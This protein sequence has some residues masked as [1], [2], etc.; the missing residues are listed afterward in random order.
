[1]YR[2][3]GHL[4]ALALISSFPALAVADQHDDK[5]PM[6]DGSKDTMELTEAAKEKKKRGMDTELYELTEDGM[7][8]VIGSVKIRA[9][10]DGVLFVPDIS[11]LT[12]GVHGFH[13]HENPDCGTAE[14]DGKT[15]PGG[16]AGGHY[17]PGGGGHNGPYQEGHKGDLPALYADEDGEVT[18]PVLAPRLTIRDLKD[19]ALIV[20]QHGDNYSDEPKALGGGGPRVACGVIGER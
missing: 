1:M 2:L 5:K 7:G 3:T 16:A 17:N 19:R 11:G 9:N 12:P 14:K 6:G 15:V 13:V 10:P 4:A 18:V 8:D 20:H